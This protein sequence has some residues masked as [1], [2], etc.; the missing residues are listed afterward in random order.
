L[1]QEKVPAGI[2][3]ANGFGKFAGSTQVEE[4]GEVETPIL[5]T[6]TLSVLEAMAASIEWTLAQAGK[7]RGAHGRRGGRRN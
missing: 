2:V 1:Y 3:V 7:C 6:N 5:L 4:L